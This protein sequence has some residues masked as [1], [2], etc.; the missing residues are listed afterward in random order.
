MPSK[1]DEPDR[2]GNRRIALDWIR[3]VKGNAPHTMMY[4]AG[5]RS[6]RPSKACG[7]GL[8]CRQIS[9]MSR[10]MGAEHW[11]SGGDSWGFAVFERKVDSLTRLG[12]PPPRMCE[13]GSSRYLSQ[14]NLRDACLQVSDLRGGPNERVD[15]KPSISSVKSEPA[16]P[17][18]AF[19]GPRG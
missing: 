18:C 6:G 11:G 19:I 2:A 5:V 9:L 3:R 16:L 1:G 14:K 13:Q 8:K 7:G 15:M 10:V 12:A 17:G 4:P